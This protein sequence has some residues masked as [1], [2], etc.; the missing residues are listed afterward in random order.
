MARAAA[1]SRHKKPVKNWQLQ[2][3]LAIG[4]MAASIV[5]AIVA[6]MFNPDRGASKTPVNDRN[7]I[8]HVNR[9]AKSWRAG[10]SSFFSSFVFLSSSWGFSSFFGSFFG[11]LML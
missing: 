5:L 9:N 10:S 4:G 7:L 11:Q 1:A 8:L 2:Y 6:M 3:G